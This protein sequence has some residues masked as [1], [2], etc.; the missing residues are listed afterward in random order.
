[1]KSIVIDAII[2]NLPKVMEFIDINLE[3]A[4]CNMKAQ[5]QIEISVEEL[6]VNIVNYAYE[7]KV[8]KAEITYEY[9]D[10]PKNVKIQLID[11]GVPYNPLAKDDPDI[12]LSVDE[13]E[14][15]GLG[16]FMV[17]KNMDDV[18]YDYIDGQNITTIFKNI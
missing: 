2:E 7:G 6:F 15:G 18:Q 14:I 1:M 5:T 12:T 11:S 4:E 9:S 17:K 13:R 8:G 10:K 3:E 16:I